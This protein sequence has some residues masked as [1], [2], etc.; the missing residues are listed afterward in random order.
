[1]ETHH[2][3]IAYSEKL[4]EDNVRDF[5]LEFLGE[6]L[7]L[8]S[9]Q[10]RLAGFRPD[11][12]FRDAAGIPTIVEI[13][14]GPLDRN[15]LYRVLEYR[16]LLRLKGGHGEVR[17]ILVANTLPERYR[18]LLD[19]HGVRV[20]LISAAT[21]AARVQELRPGTT[22]TFEPEGDSSYRSF[23]PVS[24][25]LI[26]LWQ[27]EH[28]TIWRSNPADRSKLGITAKQEREALA[29]L[30]RSGW[31]A[32]IQKG[33][34]LLNKE[35]DFRG[36][37][38]PTP[39]QS[40]QE[41]MSLYSSQYQIVGPVAFQHHGWLPNDRTTIHVYNDSISRRIRIAGSGIDFIKVARSRLGDIERATLGG[42]SDV[43]ISSRLRSLV[44]AV[45][46]WSRFGS[47]PDAFLWV[48]DEIAKRAGSDQALAH[49][50]IRYGNT[51][52]QRRL[53]KVLEEG[54]ACPKA[55]KWI[56]KRLPPT[57]AKIPWSPSL[58]KRGVTDRRWGLV[59]NYQRSK[60]IR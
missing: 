5:P 24:A 17:V 2:S 37:R 43:V 46:D 32:R 23:G 59:L 3:C 48:W 10:L 44:D 41:L 4:L 53:G 26:S 35:L 58:P 16:D 52:T 34:Y 30:C 55:V 14:I 25:A 12:V 39:Y 50:C 27:T 19:I 31:I 36:K 28:R 9:Q 51:G 15:H 22:V 29:R 6:P 33:V 1:M 54:A 8:D 45:Y 38:H 47:L 18:A 57:T 13:Q 20:V 56:H 60:P 49:L 21:L 40:I 42:T 7:T 11:L